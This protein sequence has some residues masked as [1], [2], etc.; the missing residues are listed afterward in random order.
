[1]VCLSVEMLQMERKMLKM[2]KVPVVVLNMKGNFVN[3]PQWNKISKI[4]PIIADMTQ[5]IT[6]EELETLS[7]DEINE[8]VHKAFEYDD[9]AWQ[10]DNKIVIDH[11]KRAE[12][13]HSLLYQC[14]KTLNFPDGH[15]D[16]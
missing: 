10:R 14:Y 16:L 9:F 4:N 5:V 11:P 6:K 7:V 15:E 13:L 3:C 1:M 12:G 2:L 8:R